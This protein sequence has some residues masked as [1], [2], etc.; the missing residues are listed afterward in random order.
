M[1]TNKEI[2][3][4]VNKNIDDIMELIQEDDN[5]GFC[6]SCG[7]LADSVEPDAR[8]YTCDECDEPAVYG[9]QELL[10]YV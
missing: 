10:F 9:A 1:K 7:A 3:T 4:F 5:Q 8:G 6:V 2:T